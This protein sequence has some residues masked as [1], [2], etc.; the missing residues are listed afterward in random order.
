MATRTESRNKGKVFS[1]KN[2]RPP[3]EQISG[4]TPCTVVAKEN[5]ICVRYSGDWSGDWGKAIFDALRDNGCHLEWQC[6]LGSYVD[7]SMAKQR[8]PACSGCS[9][10]DECLEVARA[11]TPRLRI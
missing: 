6:Y 2:C 7:C 8:K 4:L 10:K 3:A 9:F 11:R 1:V 5:Q